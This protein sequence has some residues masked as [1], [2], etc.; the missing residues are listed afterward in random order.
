[1]LSEHTQIRDADLSD[2]RVRMDV[3]AFQD[4]VSTR[5]LDLGHRKNCP[6]RGRDTD[7]DNLVGRAIVHEFE[8]DLFPL[9]S[10]LYT[11]MAG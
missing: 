11:P 4:Q 1:M 9:T 2:S 7:R 5:Y 10:H 8:R 6:H 3:K